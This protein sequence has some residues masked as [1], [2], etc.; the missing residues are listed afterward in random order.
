M[1]VLEVNYLIQKN[2]FGVF[3]DFFRWR[4]ATVLGTKWEHKDARKFTHFSCN[5][6]DNC[7][8]EM[9]TMLRLY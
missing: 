9:F 6:M 5:E 2:H 7:K 8:A 3:Y 4:Y 1:S